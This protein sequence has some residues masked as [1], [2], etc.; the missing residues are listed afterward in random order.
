MICDVCKKDVPKTNYNGITLQNGETVH[1]C[2]KHFAQYRKYGKFID[3]SPKSV[4]DV[5]DFKVEGNTA[6]IYTRR[7]NGEI[8]GFFIIDRDDLDEVIT[9]KWR[10]WHG[11]YYTGVQHPIAISDFLLKDRPNNYVV[12]HINQNPS[13]NRRCNL[14]IVRQANNTMNKRILDAN[15]SGVAGVWFDKTRD[16]WLAEIKFNYIKVHLGRYK[17][18]E[19]ACYA[20]YI[21]ELI[22][23]GCFRSETNDAVLIP[24]ANQ[25]DIKDEI[26]TYVSQ[27]VLGKIPCFSK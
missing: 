18:Y 17:K 1:V 22:I 7:S 8:S 21:A 26:D 4:K 5:N 23:F 11:R 25:C 3:S 20:R 2:G 16:K 19:D 13:D 24:I 9:R 10:M 6:T 27:R 12:D 14:R 15:S